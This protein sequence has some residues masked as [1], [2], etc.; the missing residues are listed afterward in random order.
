MGVGLLESCSTSVPSLKDGKRKPRKVEEIEGGEIK[1][2]WRRFGI[3]ERLRELEDE[4]ERLRQE[5]NAEEDAALRA[6][7]IIE[8]FNTPT[9]VPVAE[10]IP[11]RKPKHAIRPVSSHHHSYVPP[12]VKPTVC[13]P[14]KL[15]K[16]FETLNPVLRTGKTWA[17][18]PPHPSISSQNIESAAISLIQRGFLPPSSNLSNLILAPKLPIP[19]DVETL[20]AYKWALEK[21]REIEGG[22]GIFGVLG[23]EGGWEC[24]E[25]RKVAE[26]VKGAE[27]GVSQE[28]VEKR[29]RPVT[30]AGNLGAATAAEDK[31]VGP[32][33]IN[34]ADASTKEEEFGEDYRVVIIRDGR[35]MKETPSFLAF[36][37]R[38]H[39]NW[40][41]CWL[42]LRAMERLMRLNGV[43]WAEVRAT[44]IE[45]LASLRP[46]P[47]TLIP[48]STLPTAFRNSIEVLKTLY[49]P[50]RT[51]TH[52]PHPPTLAA[53]KIQRCWRKHSTRN[54][55]KD[56]LK[57]KEAARVIF[58][59]WTVKA[60]RNLIRASLKSQFENV[61]LKR[62]QRLSLLMR[63]EWPQWVNQKKVFVVMGPRRGVG[64]VLDMVVGKAGLLLDPLVSVIL[65]IPHLTDEKRQYIKN[66][67]EQGFPENNP[68]NNKKLIL[69]NPETAPN[70]VPG[71]N[72]ASMLNVSHK[73]LSE[74]KEL[75]EYKIAMLICDVVGEPE[76]ILSSN[77]SIPLF[78][79][80]PECFQRFFTREKA[81]ALLK[82]AGLPVAPVVRSTG[83]ERDFY[84]H[85][86]KAV[87][88]Y[89]DVPRWH[90]YDAKTCVKMDFAKPDGT[91][92]AWIDSKYLQQGN[93]P[94]ANPFSFSNAAQ[95]IVETLNQKQQQKENQYN[96]F[97]FNPLST[98]TVTALGISPI[99][100]R[101]TTTTRS[102][103]KQAA[104]LLLVVKVNIRKH[105]HLTKAPSYEAFIKRWSG[106]DQVLPSLRN[107]AKVYLLP[108]I[109]GGFI[110]ACPVRD[111]TQLRRIEIGFIVDP[112]G[113]TT[114]A[115]TVEVMMGPR[116]EQVG[117]I[118]PQQSLSHRRVLHVIEQLG[119]TCA[120]RGVVGCVTVQ[121]HTWVDKKTSERQEWFTNVYLCF[122]PSILRSISVSLYTGCKVSPYSGRWTFKWD[123]IPMHLTKTNYAR[124]TNMKRLK[125][126]YREMIM[127]EEGA[128]ERRVAVVFDNLRHT[129]VARMTKLGLELMVKR[130]GVRF[131]EWTRKGTFMGHTEAKTPMFF[132]TM[133]LGEDFKSAVRQFLTDLVIINR[134]LKHYDLPDLITNF[135]LVGAQMLHELK[136]AQSNDIDADLEDEAVDNF[137]LTLPDLK[138]E[139][140][141]TVRQA[142]KFKDRKASIGI[143]WTAPS[144]PM[145]P[146]KLYKQRPI[147]NE[148]LL[149][150]PEDLVNQQYIRRR[151]ISVNSGL[152]RSAGNLVTVSKAVTSSLQFDDAFPGELGKSPTDADNDEDVPWLEKVYVDR[153][154]EFPVKEDPL[155]ENSRVVDLS[156]VWDLRRILDRARNPDYDL[157]EMITNEIPELPYSRPATSMATVVHEVLKAKFEQQILPGSRR[158]YR[159]SPES[160]ALL[161]EGVPSNHYAM[162]DP[163]FAKPVILPPYQADGKIQAGNLDDEAELARAEMLLER[164][165]K[166]YDEK[167]A[168]SGKRSSNANYYSIKGTT[169]LLAS[170]TPG[171]GNSST[172]LSKPSSAEQQGPKMEVVVAKINRLSERA[173][174]FEAN[175]EK[176]M[177]EGQRKLDK[178][179]DDKAREERSK[180]LG[181]NLDFHSAMDF[182]GYGNSMMDLE[183]GHHNGLLAPAEL[184]HPSHKGKVRSIILSVLSGS[185]D[186]IKDSDDI[187]TAPP[188]KLPSRQG[189]T[190]VFLRAKRD[191][192]GTT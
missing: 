60:H 57:R 121:L 9:A 2:N 105:I 117:L 35:I 8:R 130:H 107:P 21:L 68:I 66:Q 40:L 118:C 151:S 153:V 109:S 126:N 90:F 113:E 181:G 77:L 83:K 170:L 63:R 85:L 31:T 164:F 73:A 158:K 186:N 55:F 108:G 49:N 98:S 36:K 61:H 133:T 119:K 16:T 22:K 71:S 51:Y 28:E 137:D 192:E 29:R 96:E 59:V 99:S 155:P 157:E 132:S 174:A 53:T 46:L 168:K 175:F 169:S 162:L 101:P 178:A 27:V 187:D 94:A 7:Q 82:E 145:S 146:S 115:N 116:F 69:I 87:M 144:R 165:E 6:T 141:K 30:P 10:P 79:V 112:K 188:P 70:F 177:L 134:R 4:A 45:A 176:Q 78:G 120:A 160:I 182:D 92:D 88:T 163:S 171:T 161:A 93:T 14:A 189:R 147:D 3:A 65:V 17:D 172:S 100:T 173:N 84:M 25:I 34:T 56:F 80:T 39:E 127:G 81:R 32:T 24:V 110:E 131:N 123:D 72:V 111:G 42:V 37:E 54:K 75:I 102:G 143:R 103:F 41:G 1:K 15:S 91:P 43:P 149:F 154:P 11:T 58:K 136:T 159:V 47:S 44:Y 50:S 12:R 152:R 95:T 33:R 125:D 138:A 62:F 38:N 86:T 180:R 156:D 185:S 114:L 148:G 124:Y 184:A 20:E 5:R 97:K 150:D 19:K 104:K 89:R 167:Q 74:I 166:D 179:R 52:H 129:E 190:S 140:I 13:P 128:S 142:V 191:R 18:I 122:S 26:L 76:V 48:H 183:G 23:K 64:E 139:G 106:Q 135:K 67:L